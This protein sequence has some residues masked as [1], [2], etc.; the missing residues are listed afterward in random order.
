[1]TKESFEISCPVCKI[2]LRLWIPADKLDE[3]EDGKAMGCVG[4]STKLYFWRSPFGAE[5]I[6]YAEY[7]M[8][9]GKVSGTGF[10]ET[11]PAAGTSAADTSVVSG[12]DVTTAHEEVKPLQTIDDIKRT[13]AT[14]KVKVYDPYEKERKAKAAQEKIDA[15]ERAK[16][17]HHAADDVAAQLKA[18]KEKLKSELMAEMK[19]TIEE[20]VAEEIAEQIPE[21]VP[22]KIP[23]EEVIEEVI[24]EL[25]EEAEAKGPLVLLIEGGKLARTVGVNCLSGLQI[26][27]ITA[28]NST[29]AIDLLNYRNPELVIVDL[30]LKDPNNPEALLD[31]E[32]LLRHF[33]SMG[34]KIPAV[35]TTGRDIL[36]DIESDPKWIP[37]NVKGF[38]QKGDP[39]WADELKNKVTEIL[40]V[41]S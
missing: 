23:Q 7:E 31:G 14:A 37:L 12:K 39:F 20:E 41:H 3:W 26:E 33:A 34:H 25:V 27:L 19:T 11:T 32:E 10:A 2:K 9:Q 18:M 29:E 35:V 13:I 40:Q 1:M 4:C 36:I 30:Y 22:E 8:K 15:E 6:T 24:E 5:V 16:A 21:E 38:V 17:S 28:T